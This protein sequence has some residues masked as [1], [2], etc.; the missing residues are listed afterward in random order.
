MT[1]PTRAQKLMT[2]HLSAPATP[3]PYHFILCD[4]SL[5]IHGYVKKDHT[6]HPWHLTYQVAM[7][8]WYPRYTSQSQCSV[9]HQH[10]TAKWFSLVGFICT[11]AGMNNFDTVDMAGFRT[12]FWVWCIFH[13]GFLSTGLLEWFLILSNTKTE[14]FKSLYSLL[15]F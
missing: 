14:K 8:F 15:K 6:K 10:V 3:P 4:Q 9:W 13:A 12:M 7:V 5:N 1:T 2:H 11:V